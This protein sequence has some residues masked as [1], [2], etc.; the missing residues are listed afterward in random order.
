MN[1]EENKLETLV[2][3]FKRAKS[4]AGES[5]DETEDLASLLFLRT[6]IFDAKHM[7]Q[8]A[9]N[10]CD[11]ALVTML[12]EDFDGEE[13]RIENIGTVGLTSGRET[14]VTASDEKM[15]ELVAR[16][17]LI[18]EDGDM[19]SEDPLEAGMRVAESIL[20]LGRVSWRIKSFAEFGMDLRK[21]GMATLSKKK[22]RPHLGI[23]CDNIIDS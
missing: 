16:Y 10:E 6:L 22:V 17:V 7:L 14:K 5:V 11:D 19:I 1:S 18:D 20:T 15:A 8:D 21:L 13:Q 4:L 2:N 3:L 12:E 23:E 9:Q